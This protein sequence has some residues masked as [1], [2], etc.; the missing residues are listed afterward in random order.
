LAEALSAGLVVSLL[1]S[2]M[3]GLSAGGLI[4]PAYM[5]LLLDQPWRLL[6]TFVAAGLAFGAYRVLAGQLILFGRRRFVA[7]LL[8]GIAAK[9]AVLLS[10]PALSATIAVPVGVMGFV[11][12][13]LIANDFER[14]GVLA[15]V[16]MVA[17][18]TVAAALVV[19]VLGF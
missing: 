7:M 4:T 14:Q 1:L 5:A 10:A 16:A 12:P 13:G 18:A 6:G 17:T 9:W 15:T 3:I 8:L 2:E 11:L 19:R